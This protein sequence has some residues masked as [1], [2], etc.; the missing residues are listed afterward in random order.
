MKK[1]FYTACLML[2]SLMIS[3]NAVAGEK[4]PVKMTWELNGNN[5][6]MLIM[7]ET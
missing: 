4:S 1:L 3:V 7:T 6:H 5:A 2:L